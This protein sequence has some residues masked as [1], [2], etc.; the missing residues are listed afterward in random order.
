MGGLRGRLIAMTVLV[1]T[2]AVVMSALFSRQVVRNEFRRL[3]SP[4]PAVG[5]DAVAATL[6]DRFH[7]TG[8]W[9][10]A[11]SLLERRAP[12]T[13]HALL[14]V[15]PGGRTLAASAPPL[16]A[17]R[18]FSREGRLEV[19]DAQGSLQLSL[20]GP[21]RI[22]ILAPGG[23]TAA[24][25]YAL[26]P[27][28]PVPEPPS[29]FLRSVTRGLWLGA[30]LAVTLGVLI[31]SLFARHIARPLAELTA[32][33]RRMESGDLTPRSRHAATTRWRRSRAASTPWPRD[34]GGAR[35]R[36]AS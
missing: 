31:G 32:A 14:L 24:I 21:Q 35:P 36:A 2:T 18:A 8:G 19:R 23:G 34:C 9:G 29:G 25:L 27:I 1:A 12:A 17:A 7:A 4:T 3:E 13:R 30:L 26:P 6:A 16:R 28:G 20:V 33:A 10:G 15:E 11:D 5:L 22:P